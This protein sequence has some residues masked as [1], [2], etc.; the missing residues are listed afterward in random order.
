MGKFHIIIEETVSETFEIE[1]RD[2]QEALN[3]AKK[4]YDNCDIVLSP[5]QLT[6]KRISAYDDDGNTVDWHEF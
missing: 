2:I 5:G 3:I 1:A 4:G 6:E